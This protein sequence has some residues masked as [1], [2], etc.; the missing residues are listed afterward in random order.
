MHHITLIPGDGIGPEITKAVTDIFAAAQ[1]PVQWEEQNAGQTTFDQS[2]ELI[3]QA[4]LTSLE[5]NR[6]ALKGPITT[7]VGKGFRSINVTLRQKY[8]LYQNVRPAKTTPGIQTRYSGVDLVLFRENTEGL[9]SGLEVYDERLGIADSFNRITKEGSRKICRA[10]FAYADKHGR[11]KVTLAHKANIL[12]MAGT[13]MLDACKEAAAEFPHIVFED[14]IIDNMC[15]QLVVK[16]EQFDVVV[17]TNLFGDIL[18]DL[19][20][21]LVGGLG[22]V[23]GA[24]VGDDMA[25][26]EAVHG[27]A[28]DIAGQGKANPTALLRSAL[29]LL[30]HIG[31]H[32]YATTIEK[33]LD[34]TLQDKSKCTGDLGGPASTGE[35][36]QAVI[37][38]LGK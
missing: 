26:F 17:T 37:G 20:A 1:V 3:P 32:E 29:M 35:F 16:P 14:K 36:A 25:I 31:E 11:K 18:S 10:A 38:N 33:A 12:K 13:L 30:R 34:L 22:V 15:M 2:G 8:D 24:N 21:G 4:L 27:S 19:C 6:V 28:P 5:K 9:Y 7:P 23:S